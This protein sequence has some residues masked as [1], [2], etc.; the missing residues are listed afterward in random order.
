MENQS[1]KNI[2]YKVL[3]VLIDYESDIKKYNHAI[4]D[5][6]ELGGIDK[7]AEILGW[8]DSVKSKW[9]QRIQN[10]YELK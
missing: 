6:N 4:D 3:E 9:N 10:V 1:I 2:T 7:I 8:D 5:Y